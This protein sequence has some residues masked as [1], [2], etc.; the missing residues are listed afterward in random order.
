M[1]PSCKRMPTKLCMMVEAGADHPG[2]PARIS[3]MGCGQPKNHHAVSK[4]FIYMVLHGR[5]NLILDDD[6]FAGF[7]VWF[8]LRWI[9]SEDLHFIHKVQPRDLL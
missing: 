3:D 4:L 9:F 8:G 6:L 7:G 1:R 2:V 5:R